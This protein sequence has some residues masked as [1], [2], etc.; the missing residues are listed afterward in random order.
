[1][2]EEAVTEEV[3]ITAYEPARTVT[4]PAQRMFAATEAAKL[5]VA[6]E[7]TRPILTGIQFEFRGTRLRMISA[8]GFVLQTL[9][10]EVDDGPDYEACIPARPLQTYLKSVKKLFGTGAPA[11]ALEFGENGLRLLTAKDDVHSMAMSIGRITGTFPDVDQMLD[12]ARNA[13]PGPGMCV[14]PQYLGLVSKAAGIVDA[15][16]VWTISRESEHQAM[17]LFYESS[18]FGKLSAWVK[19]TALIMPMFVSWPEW[20]FAA[21]E[22]SAEVESEIQEEEETDEQGTNA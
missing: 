10:I 17:A 9:E 4:M 14:S 22:P 7:P 11:I 13:T 21:I 2:T 19:G 18:N 12:G 3:V 20:V 8:N 16:C 5:F 6:D 1:M 15:H